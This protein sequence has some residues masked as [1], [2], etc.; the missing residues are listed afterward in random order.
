MVSGG[1]ISRFLCSAQ[2]YMTGKCSHLQSLLK[3]LLSVRVVASLNNATLSVV[4]RLLLELVLVSARI[5]TVIL[6]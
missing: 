6:M 5:N 2:V 1:D 4:K 3:L